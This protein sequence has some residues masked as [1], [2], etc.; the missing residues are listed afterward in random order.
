MPTVTI[1]NNSVQFFFT[2]SG[3]PPDVKNYTTYVIVHGYMYNC[4]VFRRLL[5]LAASRSLRLI[6][7]NR[8]GYPGSTPYS[9]EEVRIHASGSD[10]ERAALLSEAG[11]NLALCVNEIIQQRDLPSAGGVALVGWSL[12]NMFAMA[13]RASIVSLPEDARTRLQTCVKTA[14]LWGPPP[15]ALGIAGVPPEAYG[16]LTDPDLAPEARGPAFRNW[17]QSYFTHG[18]LS[19]RDP[20]QLNYQAPDPS[21]NPTFDDT[22][23]EELRKIVDGDMGTQCD[24][25]LAQPVFA[26]IISA[27][28]D[29]ALFSP[30][31]RA[32]WPNTQV[33][34]MYGEANPGVIL[35]AVW[36]IEQR[37]KEAIVFHPIAGANQFVM[38][39]DA[40]KALDALIRCTK[41]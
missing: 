39:D 40:N 25:M 1:P 24:T 38:W 5:P 30:D 26:P 23:P 10:E 32:A 2:D 34:Y 20:E 28:V 11:A 18:N 36:N 12:G 14:I 22:P 3:A 9:A 6:C 29:K 7:I 35:L 21:K 41:V 15:Q 13:A 16:P 4:G 33:S 17:I 8:R 37:A 27:I 31:I 19:S